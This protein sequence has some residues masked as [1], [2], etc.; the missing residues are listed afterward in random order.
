MK[1]LHLFSNYKWTGPA[2]PALNLAQAQRQL[3]ADVHFAC[4]SDP[5]GRRSAIAEQAEERGVPVRED[6]I[7]SKHLRLLSNVKDALRLNAWL[8]SERFDLIHCHQQNDHLLAGITRRYATLRP[9]IVRTVYDG[10]PPKAGWRSRLLFRK[11]SDHLFC[12]SGQVLSALREREQLDP[13]RLSHVD[14][15]V[16]LSRFTPGNLADSLRK[17]LGIPED[18]FVVGLV[19]RMQRHRRFEIA[20]EAL[21]QACAEEPRVYGLFVGRGTHRA[22]VCDEPIE[23]AGLQGRIVLPGYLQ[24]HEFVRALWAMS[25]KLF[26]VP[27][28]DGSCR[29]LREAQACGLAAITSR[30]GVLPEI[31]PADQTGLQVDETVESLR[32]AILKLCREPGLTSRLGQNALER[33]RERY[34]IQRVARGVLEQCQPLLVH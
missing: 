19:S 27:G 9:P 29:A 17:Q 1:I 24:G 12:I 3:G 8:K 26:L 34:D 6:L 7:L 4:G 2:E 22:A 25:C 10:A 11:F 31:N 30:R 20:I 21:R 16:D 13:D 14:T 15:A 33:A 32:A 5:E 28:S 23:A 18:A